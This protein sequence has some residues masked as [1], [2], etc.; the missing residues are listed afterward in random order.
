MT[1][2]DFFGRWKQLGLPEQECQKIFKAKYPI[3]T[4]VNKNKLTG[5]GLSDLNGID[6]NPNNSVGAGIIKTKSA[7]IGCLLRL[8]PNLQANMYRL[9]VRSSNS[10]I[11]TS[12]CNLL[13]EHF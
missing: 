12:F 8:E 13:E 10:H 7:Q 3:S 9:T 2:Q 5:F 4:D 1:S 6:P 11:S